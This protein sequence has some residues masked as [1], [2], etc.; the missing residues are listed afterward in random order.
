MR[1]FFKIVL[2]VFI[3]FI[4]LIILLTIVAKLSENK[5]TDIALNKVSETIDAPVLIDDVSFNLLRK[6][7][8]AT[9]ELNGVWLGKSPKNEQS[10]G[11]PPTDTI[12]NFDR[13]F[14]SVKTRP[15]ID[16]I[17]EVKRI[18]VHG[19]DINYSIDTAGITNI[20][21]LMPTDTTPA[22]V[23]TT[24]SEPL[25]ATLEMLSLK[26]IR[27]HYIDSTMKMAARLAIPE[28][29][30]KA[31]AQN[32][33]YKAN[34]KG[35]L[36]LSGVEYEG[37]NAHLMKKTSVNFKVDYDDDSVHIDHLNLLTDGAEINLKGDTK[38]GDE[39][40]TDLT[41]EITTLNL[42][43]L[44]KYAP[45][46]IMQEYGVQKVEGLLSMS[47][48]VKGIYSE[49]QMPKVDAHVNM[50]KGLVRTAD[51]PQLKNIAFNGDITNGVL[52]NN[53]TTQV[54]F[55][56]FGFETQNSRFNFAFSVLN[57][58]QP[59]Y[60]VTTDMRIDVS[61][62]KQFI[63]DTLVK[64]ISG[65]VTAKLSTKGQLP[66]SIGDDFI[67]KVAENSRATVGFHNFYVNMGDTLL[68]NNFNTSLSYVPNN[69]K[70]ASLSVQVPAYELDV[71]KTFA[72]IGFTGKVTQPEAMKIVIRALDLQTNFASING[73]VK[74][75][76]PDFPKYDVKSTLSLNLAEIQKMVPD[77]LVQNLRGGV[78][79]NLTTYGEVDV[80]SIEARMNDLLFKQTTFDL[81]MNNIGLQMPDDTLMK[82]ENFSGLVAFNQQHITI[83]KLG[84]KFAGLEFGMD[85]T[86]I[87][88]LYETFIQE[89]RDTSLIVQTNLWL[90]NFDYALV[91]ALMP[92]DTLATDSTAVATD[93]SAPSETTETASTDEPA[94]PTGEPQD[95]T[96]SEPEHIL[97]DFEAMGLPHFLMRGKFSINQVKYEKNIIDDISLLFRFADSLYVIDQFKLK[98][99]GGEVNTSLKFDARN[100]EQPVI[101]IKNTV[102]HLDV[103]ELLMVNDNFGDTALTYEKVTG[104]LTSELHTR[105]FVVDGDYPTKR[106]RA[107]GHFTLENGSIHDYKPLVEL[108][109][110]LTGVG[111]LKELAELDFNTL[112]TSLF[113]LNNKVYIPKTDVVSSALD[114]SAFAMHS[115]G[116]DE[117]Y[118][119]HLKLHLGD[120][121]TGKSD[122]LMEAQAKANK[123]DGDEVERNGINLVSMDVD[124]KKKNG[125]DNKSLKEDLEKNIKRQN[126]FLNLLF[127]PQLV[128]FSTALDRTAKKEKIL[129]QEE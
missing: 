31:R 94:G 65:I 123:K 115:L 4:G 108:S 37:T 100:W 48:S 69:F 41:I 110:G 9:I 12:L 1:K 22:E 107:K 42:A 89:R 54:D 64:S 24:P 121:L 83:N 106:M 118:E 15:L 101:D 57:I 44:I 72:D 29:E 105:V 39:I 56:N 93:L 26:N 25:D 84:G 34:I 60:N 5:I 13:I 125:F 81:T 40:L 114:F 109:N 16:G 86:E 90:G 52:Q 71:M 50:E 98:A 67:N 112:N 127:N 20:D 51:Y 7:P 88:N 74:F 103:K 45:D 76:N 6:F 32:D 62:F 53:K 59:M 18:D 78:T 77:T 11:L 73:K 2:Y 116:E 111:G 128:N 19:A 99:F 95:T 17:I 122:K 80:D 75:E 23:D 126:S 85:S 66:D 27:V 113:L 102:D 8:L 58:D 104:I 55:D 124:G 70:I 129:N 28:M 38:L 35:G 92:A 119:Y 30:I 97:P 21:F 82:L 120:V 61:D 87:L 117:D 33:T 43:E 68:V 10:S 63:P 91:E 46:E 47:A 96:A 49:K 3:G 36:E 14:V 79:L